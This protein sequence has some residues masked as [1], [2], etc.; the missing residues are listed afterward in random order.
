MIFDIPTAP[1]PI[2]TCNDLFVNI[3]L[4]TDP[5]CRFI[6]INFHKVTQTF[7]LLRLI[8]VHIHFRPSRD[9]SDAFIIRQMAL[10]GNYG[11]V[12]NGGLWVIEAHIRWPEDQWLSKSQ[13]ND[14]PCAGHVAITLKPVRWWYPS[15]EKIDYSCIREIHVGLV[16]CSWWFLNRCLTYVIL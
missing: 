4:Q 16:R 8:L 11:D 12:S 7:F 15:N 1:T 10:G 9:L 5:V 13:I 6:F 14:L 3:F 2:G